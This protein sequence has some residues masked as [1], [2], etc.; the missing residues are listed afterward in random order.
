MNSRE[1]SNPALSEEIEESSRL[2]LEDGEWDPLRDEPG[3]SHEPRGLRYN[4]R[5]NRSG[6]T[7]RTPSWIERIKSTSTKITEAYVSETSVKVY[8][9]CLKSSST[10]LAAIWRETIRVVW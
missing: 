4:I 6:L 5:K 7:P 10:R 3:Q 2:L 1:G 9:G 8:T